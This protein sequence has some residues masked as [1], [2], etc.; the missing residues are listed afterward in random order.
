MAIT[1]ASREAAELNPHLD[2]LDQELLAAVVERREQRPGLR[3]GDYV[4]FPC[5]RLER[6]SDSSGSA[7]QT[8]PMGSFFLYRSGACEYSGGH[9]PP[10]PSADLLP[11]SATLPG[12]FWFFHHGKVGPGRAVYF[13]IHCRVFRSTAPYAGLLGAAFQPNPARIEPLKASLARQ[14]AACSEA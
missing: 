9:N 3:L 11:T 2:A 5:G 13:R 12:D 14:L 4:L 7:V 10:V 1:D 6:L 8:T